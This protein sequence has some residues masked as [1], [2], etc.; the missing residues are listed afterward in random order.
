V[1]AR[2]G[3]SSSGSTE[4]ARSSSESRPWSTRS[5]IAAAVNVLVI[6]PTA[7]TVSAVFG[8]PVDSSARP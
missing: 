1:T 2:A 8:A 7:K 3:P 4:P 5:T 6:E